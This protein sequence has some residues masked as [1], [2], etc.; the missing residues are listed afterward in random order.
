MSST[1]TLQQPAAQATLL[2][3]DDE[4][5]ILS[6][7]QRLFRPV[8]YRILT[9]TGGAQ[10]LEI[11]AKEK[12][13]LIVSDMRMPEMDGAA[14]LEQAA[15]RWPQVMRILLT[16]YADLSSAVA[17][18][19][20]GNIYRYLSKP[21]EDNDIRIT[22]QQAL[23]RQLLEARVVE[24]NAQL[25][26]LNTNLEARV[27]S[28]TQEIRQMLGQLE[29][30]HKELKKSF[31][32]S[33]RV[34]STLI[35]LR[36]GDQSG[37]SRRVAEHAYALARRAGMNDADTQQVLY[38]G[39]LHNIGKLGLPDALINK[40]LATL[41]ISER[42]QVARYPIIGQAALLAVEPLQD[43]ALLIRH[44]QERYDGQGFPDSLMGDAIPLGA[45][46]LAIAY[47]YDALQAGRLEA[48]RLTPSQARTYLMANKGQRYDAKLLD[49]FI[50]VLDEADKA[51]AAQASDKLVSSGNLKPGMVVTRDLVTGP[52]MLLLPRGRVLDVALIAKIR[53]FEREENGEY[54]IYVK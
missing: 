6:S 40:P 27:A 54:Q 45:R 24:Q 30:T 49:M 16:G 28:Q 33:V 52:G 4:P 48:S 42:A 18:V 37:H 32:T 9:A 25:K 43:A 19:N 21:W 50:A 36:D 29:V 11:L 35:E 23:E 46:I 12:V 5:N 38:A 13:D 14:F 1:N 8:G 31:L 39:L 34:F 15:S 17:A 53:T 47:D 2:F 26:E 3:V 20:K 10:G 7:L 44:H 22:V 41:S 51:T